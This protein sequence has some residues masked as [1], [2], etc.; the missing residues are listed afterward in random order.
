[1]GAILTILGPVLT[2]FAL[3]AYDRVVNH[4]KSTSVGVAVGGAVYEAVS[5]FGCDP[6]LLGPAIAG[7]IAALPKVLG[8]DA[9]KIAPTVWNAVKEAAESAKHSKQVLT[10]AEDAQK[11]AAEDAGM[12]L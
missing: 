7:A 2:K 6:S 4:Y 10:E 3:W 12:H 1:M 5:V 8:S 9:D 11:K